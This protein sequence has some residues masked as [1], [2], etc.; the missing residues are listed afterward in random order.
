MWVLG[1]EVFMGAVSIGEI[2]PPAA[3]NTDLLSWLFCVINDKD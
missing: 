1:Q 3:G 2:T